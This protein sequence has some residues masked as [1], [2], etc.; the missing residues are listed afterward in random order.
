NALKHTP[1]GGEVRIIGRQ[2]AADSVEIRVADNGPGIPPDQLSHVFERFYQVP[3]VR[4]GS[5]LGLAI[6][7]EI[8]WA[9]S[10]TI[11]ASS[12]P[13]K[14]TEF[15]VKLPATASTSPAQASQ[16]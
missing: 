4:T 16:N 2:P 11:E 9:H 14:G 7:R 13:G 10:G 3:G 8:V 1:E 6:A 12:T 15:I 5:G